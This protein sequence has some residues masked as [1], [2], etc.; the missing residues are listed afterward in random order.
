M[1]LLYPVYGLLGVICMA[2]KWAYVVSIVRFC[3]ARDPNTGEY[4]RHTCVTVI[5][6]PIMFI[7]YLV[8]FLCSAFWFFCWYPFGIF[9]L[10]Y[11]L[12]FESHSIRA[13]P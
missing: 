9:F 6:G 4:Q 11:R 7:L 2:A 8:C 1:T 13:N 12:M 10:M 3:A 5:C